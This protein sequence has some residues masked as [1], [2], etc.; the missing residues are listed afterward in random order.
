MKPFHFLV[1]VFLVLGLCPAVQAQSPE[2]M[3]M[4][5]LFYEEKDLVISPTRYPKPIHQVAENITV[6]D[7][8]EIEAMNA[9]TVAD[10]LRWIP[11]MFLNI[12]LD[13]GATSQ[14][15]IQGSEDRHVTVL[16]DGIRWNYLSGG[17]AETITIPVAVIDRIEVIK[18]PASSAWGSSLGGIINIITRPATEKESRGR[19]YASYGEAGSLDA[20]AE[21]SGGGENFGY[22]LYAG[23]QESDGLL[24]SRSMDNVSLFSKFTVALSKDADLGLNL[25]YSNPEHGLGSFPSNDI[26]SR[27]EG[28]T[29]YA[30][31]SLDIN[32]PPRSM[33]NITGYYISQDLNQKNDVLGLGYYGVAGEPYLHSDYEE[34]VYGATANLVWEPAHQT[35]VMGA[36]ISQGDLN[37]TFR[38]GNFLQWVGAPPEISASPDLL[39]W[40]AYFNDTL[41]LGRWAVTPGVRLDHNTV[42]GYFF[43]PSLGVTFQHRNDLLFRGTISRGFQYPALTL[44]EGGGVFLDP[45]PDLEAEEVWSYQIGVETTS[46]AWLQLKA[47]LFL[48]DLDKSLLRVLYGGGPPSYNDLVINSGGLERRGVEVEMGTEPIG[49]FSLRISG[50]FVEFDRFNSTGAL[51]IYAYNLIL[52][53]DN[54]GILTARLAGHYEDLDSAD[55]FQSN[56]DDIIWDL[57]ISKAFTFGGGAEARIFVT[58]HNLFDGHQY[59]LGDTKNP[60]RWLEGGIRFAF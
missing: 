42:S 5:E 4:L 3:R 60:S 36:E 30:N 9:H 53:Y 1:V 16:L 45:N 6:I 34:D 37:Q 8:E 39:S 52:L 57:N 49:N 10:V 22:Y 48:H 12:S 24:D 58:A 31:A 21:A 54:P 44:T 26:R 56:F 28:R 51:E 40:A 20:R 41:S 25:G 13:Y 7:S 33:L 27:T 35:V 23:K 11:G 19:V 55:I 50:T 15:G 46:L 29:V 14:L 17:N 43:S 47:T 32:L 59:Q 18:G 38:T 2:E